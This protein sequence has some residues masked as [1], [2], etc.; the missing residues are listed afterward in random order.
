LLQLAILAATV[1][2]KTGL[3]PPGG[4]WSG[5]D[6]GRAGDP[7]LVDH[8]RNRYMVFF[9][10]NATG[11]MASVAVILMLVNRRLYKQGIRCNALNAC[12]V[13]GLLGLMLAYAAGSCRRL[14][15]SAYVIA[16][17]AAV[18]GFL[19]LQI[20][21]FLLAKR[22]VPATLEHRLPPWLLAL[23]EPLT[24]PPRKAAAAAGGEDDKQQDSGERHTEQY[25]KRKYLMLLGV[26]AASVTYQAGLSPPGGTWGGDGAM[27]AGGSATYHYAAG[28]PVL[29]DTDRARYHAFFHCNATSFVASVVVIVL[30]L[31]RRRRR[32]GAPAAP[33]WAMQS[34][35]VLDLL[36]LLGAYAAG[37]CRE[38]ETSAYVVAL[39]GAVV[40]YIALHVLLSFDA[41]AAKA[42]RLKV[43]RYFGESSD[44]NNQTGGGAAV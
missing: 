42:E 27:V 11:F 31:L 43:W 14:R 37:S 25:M 15:T 29:H 24:P 33:L 39:V 9:Y 1:T 35:V 5:S 26:L 10:C 40:V 32:R 30:L 21:L 17:V 6:D 22:V 3:N 23:F 18:V 2:Y 34:A 13:V 41:V 28:D 20:L 19:L 8:Y 44:N 36:G 12:V 16:L 7:V 4:F 38:W